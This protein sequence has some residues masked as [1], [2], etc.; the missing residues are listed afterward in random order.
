[1]RL[2]IS[3]YSL[4]VRVFAKIFTEQFWRK[5]GLKASIAVALAFFGIS[6]MKDLLTLSNCTSSK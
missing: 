3:F 2:P 5:I 4:L 6:T 1:M